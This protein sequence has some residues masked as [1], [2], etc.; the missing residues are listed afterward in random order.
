MVAGGLHRLG[1]RVDRR[2]ADAAA[3]EHDAPE[4]L[5]LA[6]H[7]ERTEDV[8]QSVADAEARELE[9]RGADGLEDDGD[10]PGRLV[11]VGDREGDALAAVVVDLDDE[12]LAGLVLAGDVRGLE[13][14]LVDVG[15]ELLLEDDSVHVRVAWVR[16]RGGILPKTARGV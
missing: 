4:P 12:E 10:G 11:R 9:R 2:D 5:H 15:G 6:R 8:R 16:E 1:D 3:A 13:G 7:A 14:H